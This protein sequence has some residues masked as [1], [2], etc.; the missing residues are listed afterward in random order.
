MNSMRGDFWRETM[1]EPKK[2]PKCSG[3]MEQ[4]ELIDQSYAVSGAQHWAES[5]AS[6]LGIGVSGDVKIISYRCFDCGYLENYAPSEKRKKYNNAFLQ[7]L[8]GNIHCNI[9]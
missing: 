8:T 2:C 5:A 9:Q 3:N 4:G 6:L 1:G 7:E